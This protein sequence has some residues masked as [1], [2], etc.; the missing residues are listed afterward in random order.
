MDFRLGFVSCRKCLEREYDLPRSRRGSSRGPCRAG[1][2]HLSRL[3]SRSRDL[4]LFPLIC[5]SSSSVSVKDPLSSEEDSSSSGATLIF[6]SDLLS[7]RIGD[8]SL[9]RGLAFTGVF[10][11]RSSSFTS[12]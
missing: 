9:S 1:G 8:L 7:G 10:S 6:L 2:V 11:L 4:E 12:L 3:R 5:A